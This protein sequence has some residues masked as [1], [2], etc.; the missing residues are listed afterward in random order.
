MLIRFNNSIN[1]QFI[2]NV[3]AIHALHPY[4]KSRVKVELAP[5][6]DLETIVSTDRSAAFKK[7]LVG[8]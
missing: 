4:S 1:R 3:G 8:E 5:P 2:I 6:T 7:W